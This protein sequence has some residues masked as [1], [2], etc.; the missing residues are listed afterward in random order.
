MVAFRRPRS[1]R[2]LLVRAREPTPISHTTNSPK[3]P[4][5]SYVNQENV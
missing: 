3:P 5:S 2:D 1:L 4:D